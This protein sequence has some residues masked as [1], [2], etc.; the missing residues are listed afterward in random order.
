MIDSVEGIMKA[1]P[2]PARARAAI[3]Q[4]VGGEQRDRR[5]CGE[6]GQPGDE[7]CLT[8]VAITEC[9]S[10]QQ[11]ACKRQGVSI[12]DPRQLGLSGAGLGGEVRQ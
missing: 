10:R 6:H 5:S 1:A 11:Q 7:N 8:P 3:S 12:N 4:R 9:A 2:A